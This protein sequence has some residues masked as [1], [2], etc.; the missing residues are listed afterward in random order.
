MDEH[1]VP[2]LENRLSTLACADGGFLVFMLLNCLAPPA[3]L[4]SPKGVDD[5]TGQRI[6]GRVRA[7]FIEKF[8]PAFTLE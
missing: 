8:H 5:G 6:R 4:A 2:T 3:P 7:R 1:C